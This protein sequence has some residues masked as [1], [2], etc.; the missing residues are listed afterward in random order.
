[1]LSYTKENA[2]LRL[3]CLLLMIKDRRENGGSVD[4]LNLS[5]LA[6]LLPL[7]DVIDHG[8]SFGLFKHGSI[9]DKRTNEVGVNVGSGSSVLDVA[10][11]V[12]V[13]G[14]GGDAE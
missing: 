11:A 4:L 9:G 12:G 2:K 10:L 1:M 8:L 3:R 13:M 5:G 7:V 14:G 6:P